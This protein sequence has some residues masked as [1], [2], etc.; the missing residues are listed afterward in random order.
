M[1]I[2]IFPWKWESKFVHIR[3]I[4]CLVRP[5]AGN[6][7]SIEHGSTTSSTDIHQE[8]R[9]GK[10]MQVQFFIAI[11]II[12]GVESYWL[13]CECSLL[14]R[15]KVC[16]HCRVARPLSNLIRGQYVC[17]FHSLSLS[18]SL[19]HWCSINTL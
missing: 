9:A 11:G 19:P 18:W 15:A 17:F 5:A 8:A 12:I 6:V 14:Y 13:C 3:V 7:L 1:Q 16:A 4:F 2:V 10:V